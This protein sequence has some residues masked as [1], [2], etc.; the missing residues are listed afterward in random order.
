M[1]AYPAGH[2]GF[3][4]FTVLVAAPFTQVIVFLMTPA[5][6]VNPSVVSDGAGV[7]GAAELFAGVGVARGFGV[8]VVS[9]TRP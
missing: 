1:S 9:G 8:I 7:I 6:I 5:P 4:A 2:F 3:T